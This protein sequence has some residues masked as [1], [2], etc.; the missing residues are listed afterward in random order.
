[1]LPVI[2]INQVPLVRGECPGCGEG[3]TVSLAKDVEFCRLVHVFLP[4]G[5][6]KTD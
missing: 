6:F 4:V 5:V 1:M 3:N 2:S